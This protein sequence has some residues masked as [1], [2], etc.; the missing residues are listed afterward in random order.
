LLLRGKLYHH[1]LL[2]NTDHL[3]SIAKQGA[4]LEDETRPLSRQDV[5]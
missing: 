1:L 2:V 4:T 5:D 3:T